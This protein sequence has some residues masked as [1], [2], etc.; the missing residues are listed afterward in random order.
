V[1]GP[2]VKDLLRLLVVHFILFS[3]L[4]DA[5]GKHF[6]R[7]GIFPIIIFGAQERGAFEKPGFS[8]KM[9]AGGIRIWG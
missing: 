2:I 1:D 5:W 9:S 4:Y 8:S 7:F 3:L 6:L